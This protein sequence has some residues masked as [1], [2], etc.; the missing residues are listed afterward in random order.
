MVGK[1]MNRSQRRYSFARVAWDISSFEPGTQRF[2]TSENVMAVYI[3]AP[4]IP[5]VLCPF[6]G[7]EDQGEMNEAV[8]LEI[9][10]E[11]GDEIEK[12]DVFASISN[13]YG[14]Y[15]IVSPASGRIAC[16]WCEKGTTVISD[17]AL[18]AIDTDG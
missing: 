9:H 18:A 4:D 7:E 15:D 13:K 2:P 14:T 11:E 6:S 16:V 17:N 5:A 10:F 12:G 8:I 1:R 3:E